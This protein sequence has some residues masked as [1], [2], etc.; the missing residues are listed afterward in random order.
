M[1]TTERD[2]YTVLGV[3][4]DASQDDIKK[5]YRRLAR[6]FHPDMHSGTKKS[7]MEEKFKELNQAYEVLSEPETR[8]KYDRYGANW[9]E[10]E[11]YERARQESG[12]RARAQWGAS[13]DFQQQ[14][15]QDFGD[16]FDMFFTK[17]GRAAGSRGAVDGEDLETTVRLRLREVLDGVTRRIQLSERV[18]C[19]TCNGTGA[20]KNK[21]CPTCNGLGYKTEIRTLD[22]KIPAGVQDG[23]RVRVPAKGGPGLR[24]GSRGDLYLHV[25]VEPS[26]IFTRDGDDLLVTLP[27]WPWEAALGAEVLAPTLTDQVRVKIPPG[28]RSGAK[29]RLRGKGLPN[30]SG[31]RG[32]LFFVLQ[33]LVPSPLTP[34][35]RALFEQ[36]AKL[37]HPDPR[38]DLLRDAKLG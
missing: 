14:E 23:T 25:Q 12:S 1:A 22:V 37:P 32:D 9:K 31:G 20:Q 38:A 19:A 15:G 4:R 5:A 16:I 17:R 3:L 10:A 35:Q 18:P 2:Y 24:G 7:Q 33:M 34:E 27:I 13:P 6:Q 36:L 11:A 26:R 8:K 21:P 30:E 28:S 29:L